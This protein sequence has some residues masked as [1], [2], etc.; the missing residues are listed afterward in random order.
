[1]KLNFERAGEIAQILVREYV[2]G[3]QVKSAMYVGD[4]V[5]KVAL[6]ITLERDGRQ[7]EV[8]LGGRA[9]LGATLE[10][11]AGW[12]SRGLPKEWRA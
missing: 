11:Q 3:C 1:M 7:E 12:L 2:P 10:Q 4:P 6:S 8:K 5:D 9:L